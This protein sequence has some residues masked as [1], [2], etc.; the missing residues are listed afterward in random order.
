MPSK[1]IQRG[2]P[3]PQSGKLE[4]VATGA[5]RNHFRVIFLLTSCASCFN[6]F[7]R[8]DMRVDVKIPGGVSAY[9]IDLRG[10]RYSTSLMRLVSVILTIY[11]DTKQ[12]KKYGKRHMSRH[13]CAPFYT[14]TILPTL[15]R[16]I[17]SWILLRLLKENCVSFKRLEHSS[18]KAGRLALTPKSKSL[19]LSPTI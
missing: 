10:E 14:R 6:A 13:Y 9:V 7:S 12:H 18:P 15:W 19:P 17:A 16:P 8:V 5:F 2:S 4:T 11:V 1:R 3:T